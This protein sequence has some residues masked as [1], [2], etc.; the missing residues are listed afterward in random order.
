MGLDDRL[1]DTHQG[2][3]PHL[4]GIQQLF[5]VGDAVLDAQ[6]PQFGDQVLL[7]HALELPG[8]EAAGALHGLEKNVAGVTVRH[9]DVHL[10]A[11]RLPSLHIAHEMDAPGVPRPLQELVGLPLQVGTLGGLGPD[12]QQTHPRLGAAQH[13]LGVVGAHEGELE[14]IL[15]GALGRGAAVNEDGPP[16][17][18][19]DHRGH[20]ALDTLDQQRGGREQSPRAAGG[21]EGVPPALL[22]HIEAHGE[23]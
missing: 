2:G 7:E 23:G 1:A 19:G 4:A 3:A 18:G 9:D 16:L 13:V 17:A 22:E 12:V 15:R 5:E 10:A 6:C 21:D 14:Q 20:D 11:D 8:Q